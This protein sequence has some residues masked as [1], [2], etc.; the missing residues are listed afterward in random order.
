LNTSNSSTLN[1][2]EPPKYS[3][4]SDELFLIFGPGEKELL[5]HIP[6]SF[7]PPNYF[8]AISQAPNDD[9]FFW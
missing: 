7:F 8:I 5:M 3:F 4:A 6:M 1:S 9:K 2:L